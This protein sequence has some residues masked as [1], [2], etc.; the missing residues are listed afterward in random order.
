M[1]HD[2]AAIDTTPHCNTSFTNGHYSKPYINTHWEYRFNF[3]Q[4]VDLTWLDCKSF[5]AAVF[6]N[7]DT[8]SEGGFGWSDLGDGVKLFRYLEDDEPVY[9]N[10]IRKWVKYRRSGCRYCW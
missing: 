1:V 10:V 6:Y 8:A 9:I 2:V 7:A 5:L 3:E 4:R